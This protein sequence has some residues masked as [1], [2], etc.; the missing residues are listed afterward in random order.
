MVRKKVYVSSTSKDLEEHRSAVKATLERAGF[1]VGCME[2]YPAFDERPRDKCLADMA[3]CDYYVLILAWRYGFQPEDDNPRRLSCWEGL[4]ERPEPV[5]GFQT[6]RNQPRET[7][8]W[9]EAM[10]YARWLDTGLRERG[11]LPKGSAVRL[12]TEEEWEKAARGHDGR[13]FPWGESSS[14]HANIDETWDKAGPHDLGRTSAVGLYP[15]GA[16]PCGALDMA[17][18]VWEWCLNEY[19]RPERQ[20]GKGDARRVVRGGSWFSDRADARCAS[21]LDLTPGDRFDSLG[22]RLV[23]VAPIT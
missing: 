5:R 23:C 14:G 20:A 11:L 2:K 8:S 16:S 22:L 13:E 21:R 1:D 6:D 9:Y 17:G 19:D 7:V 4:A 10:A 12:P 3:E 15:A 18:N